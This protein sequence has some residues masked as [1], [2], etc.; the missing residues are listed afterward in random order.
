MGV[1]SSLV[2]QV[3]EAL[4]W[5]WEEQG[6]KQT[7][8]CQVPSHGWTRSPARQGLGALRLGILCKLRRFQLPTDSSIVS[9]IGIS[10][11]PCSK[12]D[13]GLSSPNVTLLETSPFGGTFST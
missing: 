13:S 7:L 12:P 9:P 4:G 6:T 2:K 5:K 11:F 1:N 8:C 10:N 3:L